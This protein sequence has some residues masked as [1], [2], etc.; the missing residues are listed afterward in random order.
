M[1]SAQIEFEMIN[2]VSWLPLSHG[3]DAK[4][5]TLALLQEF[6]CW[7]G[8]VTGESNNNRSNTNCLFQASQDIKK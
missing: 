7:G 2:L 5:S 6:S 3:K 4:A 8:L 1:L